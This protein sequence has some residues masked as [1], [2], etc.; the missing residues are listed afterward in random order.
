MDGLHDVFCKLPFKDSAFYYIIRKHK[1]YIIVKN[2]LYNIAIS[3]RFF[4]T[5]VYNS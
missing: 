4:Q 3:L 5:R 1:Q 2:Y